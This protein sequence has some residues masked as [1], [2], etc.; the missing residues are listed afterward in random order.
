MASELFQQVESYPWN[1]D[2]DFQNGLN[3]IL[4]NSA[5][6]QREDIA[7]QAR[8]FYYTRYGFSTS[9]RRDGVLT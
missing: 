6:E 3:A 2:S 5:S 7:L 9:R 4:G 1:E 8:C